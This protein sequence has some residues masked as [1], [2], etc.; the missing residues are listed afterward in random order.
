MKF[1]RKIFLLFYETSKR[2]WEVSGS[3]SADRKDFSFCQKLPDMHKMEECITNICLHE[4]AK[5]RKNTLVEHLEHH[6]VPKN[7]L[8]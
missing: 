8:K 4:T 7:R 3:H 6:P 5:N 1:H 2:E